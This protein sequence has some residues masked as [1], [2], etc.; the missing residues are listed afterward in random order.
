MKK[1]KKRYLE[2]EK[3][4]DESAVTGSH[5]PSSAKGRNRTRPTSAMS[6][7]KDKRNK[8]Y[9][10]DIDSD[11]DLSDAESDLSDRADN[12]SRPRSSLGRSLRRGLDLSDIEEEGESKQ[13][14]GRRG[15]GDKK[16]ERDDVVAT[17]KKPLYEEYLFPCKQWFASD[18]GDGLF[19]RELKYKNKETFFR[20]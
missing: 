19:V 1:A 8:K 17:L 9:Y 11:E 5:R 20:D 6:D 12:S 13:R 16:K 3:L 14:K 4:E 10:D 7:R 18:E 2:K 15:K